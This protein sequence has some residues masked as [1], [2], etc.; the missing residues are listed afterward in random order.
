MLYFVYIQTVFCLISYRIII[1]FFFNFRLLDYVY[2]SRLRY[3]VALA[4]LHI[5]KGICKCL[6][7]LEKNGIKLIV[8]LI[9]AWEY[10]KWLL[11]ILTRRLIFFFLID[12]FRKKVRLRVWSFLALLQTHLCPSA[13]FNWVVVTFPFYIFTFLTDL[14]SWFYQCRGV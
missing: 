9:L 8:L 12:F 6:S 7:K 11:F 10:P 4:I 14:N 13:A 1:L 5:Y 2:S 3:Y